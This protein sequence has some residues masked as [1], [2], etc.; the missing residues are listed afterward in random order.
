ML[1]FVLAVLMLAPSTDARAG[2]SAEEIRKTIVGRTCTTPGITYRFGRDGRYSFTHGL[3]MDPR[4]KNPRRTVTGTY[5]VGEGT[6]T[7][8]NARGPTVFGASISAG[9]LYYLAG[10]YECR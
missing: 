3:A 2:G 5:S 4:V 10:V 8:R 6:I 1:A 7:T 9:K